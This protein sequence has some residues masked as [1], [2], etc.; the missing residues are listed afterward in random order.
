MIIHVIRSLYNFVNNCFLIIT[1][2]VENNFGNTN[3]TKVDVYLRIDT[4]LGYNFYHVDADIYLSLP[5]INYPVHQQFKSM[6]NNLAAS[7]IN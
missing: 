3:N 4:S 1:Q 7:S 6:F 2:S 5:I